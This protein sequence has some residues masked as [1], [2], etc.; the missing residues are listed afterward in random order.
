MR[1]R[2]YAFEALTEVTASDPAVARGPLNAALRDIRT[3]MPELED[4]YL[5]SAEI[6]ER[7]KM[8]RTVWPEVA[9]TPTALSKHWLR[10][11]EEMSKLKRGG[12]NLHA[13]PNSSLPPM[14][15]HNLEEARKLM[16]RMGWT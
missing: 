14:H 9:L 7:A 13:D 1:E 11:P 2:D 10:L 4:S 6:H 3:Q 16:E 8:Y 5:L 12:S 15:K